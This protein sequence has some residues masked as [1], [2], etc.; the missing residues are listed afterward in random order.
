MQIHFVPLTLKF[1]ASQVN[2]VLLICRDEVQEGLFLPYPDFE[3]FYSTSH[4][5]AVKPNNIFHAL[6]PAIYGMQNPMRIPKLVTVVNPK[7]NSPGGLW[8]LPGHADIQEFDT[9]MTL[10]YSSNMLNKSMPNSFNMLCEKI[11]S[12][13]NPDYILVDLDPSRGK[14]NGHVICCSDG[15]IIPCQADGP[16]FDAVKDALRWTEKFKDDYDAMRLTPSR[17]TSVQ[18]QAP[19]PPSKLKVLGTMQ[20]DY[21]VQ[22]GIT[23]PYVTAE[24]AFWMRKIDANMSNSLPHLQEKG[25]ALTNEQYEAAGVHL[26][27]LC[28][29]RTPNWASMNSYIDK[30]GAPV[31]FLDA[32]VAETRKGKKLGGMEK[33]SF[34]KKVITYKRIVEKACKRIRKLLGDNI[35]AA[36]SEEPVP[37]QRTAMPPRA[38]REQRAREQAASAEAERAREAE[39]EAEMED[40][41]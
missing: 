8:L 29:S 25:L 31:A 28:L 41:E 35:I 20:C 38:Q 15:L 34:E 13:V 17:E 7:A 36:E 4:P 23:S 16:S 10:A 40:L 11:A 30:Q 14:G 12:N 37:D 26:Q 19:L 3:T 6:C 5:T 1:A 27:A 32:N 22:Q 9:N 21:T 2:F 39:S 18:A 33:E 24:F